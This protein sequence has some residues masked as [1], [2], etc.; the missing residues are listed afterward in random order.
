MRCGSPTTRV[1]HCERNSAAVSAAAAGAV[2]EGADD[3]VRR[4]TFGEIISDTIRIYAKGFPQFFAIA[5]LVAIPSLGLKLSLAFVK[6]PEGEPL[7]GT[8]RIGAA[9]AIV[10]LA[11]LLATLADLPWRAAIRDS[12][13]R[14]RAQDSPPRH[15]APR[16]ELLAADREARDVCLRQLHVLDAAAA[17]R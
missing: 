13:S 16:D 7:A 3:V 6:M 9:V 1:E 8:A 15:P 4:R 10:M 17:C 14:R 5:L 2:S 11:A 12:R